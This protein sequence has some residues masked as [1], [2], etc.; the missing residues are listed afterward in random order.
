MLTNEFFL[1]TKLYHQKLAELSKPLA[2]FLGIT[3][4]SYCKIDKNGRAFKINTYIEWEEHTVEEKYY[5]VNPCMVHPDTHSDFSFDRASN[6]AEY[7]DTPLYDVAVN[8]NCY[9]SFV[10]VEKTPDAGYYGFSF[11]TTQDNDQI[12][13]RLMNE[14]QIIKKS[15]QALNNKLSLVNARDLQEN[16]VDFAA[17]KG[18]LFYQQKGLVFNEPCK[19]QKKIQTLEESGLFDKDDHSLL[20]K[21]SLSPHEINCL[22]IYLSTHSVKKVARDLNIKVIKAF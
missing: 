14:N 6:E 13:N 9:H 8:F 2:H 15:I 20:I 7:K 17:L 4:V 12:N 16:K 5:I 19:I 22:R 1:G 3:H 11:A 18:D 10:Y 21:I